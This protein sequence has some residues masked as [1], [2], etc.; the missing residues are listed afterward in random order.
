MKKPINLPL[1][2]STNKNNVG[3]THKIKK[4]MINISFLM[5]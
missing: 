1:N 5:Y 4:N 3:I 2:I